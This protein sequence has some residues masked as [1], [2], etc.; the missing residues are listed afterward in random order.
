A[1][2]KAEW[3]FN[4]L[5]ARTRAL[6]GAEFVGAI[7]GIP[8]IGEVWGKNVTLLDRPLPADMSGLSPI[9]YRVVVGDYFRAMGVRI[10]NGRAFTDRDDAKDAPRVAIIN[11]A[12]ARRDYASS[13]PIG[14]LITVNPPV[15]LLP[16]K[17]VEDQI[18]SGS[19][20]RNYSPDRFEIVGV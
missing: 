7:N 9:Q 2:E 8:L 18:R 3:F 20:P 11:R 16:R 17:L 12:M 19:L 5:T 4:Q 6:P 15:E 13:D 1:M 14:K 10:V